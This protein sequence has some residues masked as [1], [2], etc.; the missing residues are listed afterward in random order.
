LLWG[1]AGE[2]EFAYAAGALDDDL[3]S[4]HHHCFG[5]VASAR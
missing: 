4:A 5:L 3:L 1:V 2:G